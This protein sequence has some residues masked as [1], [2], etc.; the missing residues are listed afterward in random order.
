MVSSVLQGSSSPFIISKSDLMPLQSTV[1]KTLDSASRNLYRLWTALSTG[2]VVGVANLSFEMILSDFLCVIPQ[3]EE[4]L[5]DPDLALEYME[6]SFFSDVVEAPILEEIIFRVIIQNFFHWISQKIVPDQN[7]EF[8]SCKLKLSLL[9]AIIATAILFGM[10]HLS[11][12]LGI[13]HVILAT[14][15]GI[16]YGILKE[17]QGLPAS[18]AAHMTNNAIVYGI[19][20]LV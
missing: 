6:S 20:C 5:S 15:G 10:A 12:G 19:C 9:V 13:I 17:K 16:T 3:L 11:S 1:Q 2:V 7:L 14:V 18:I 8:F 4:F